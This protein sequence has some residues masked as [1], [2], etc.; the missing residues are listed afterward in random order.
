MLTQPTPCV[1]VQIC[2][3]P[4]SGTVGVGSVNGGLHWE[5]QTDTP[6]DS[7]LSAAGVGATASKRSLLDVSEREGIRHID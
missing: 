1:A 7:L 4:A 3:E 6:T 5:E 2:V